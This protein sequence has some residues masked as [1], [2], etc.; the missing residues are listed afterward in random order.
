MALGLRIDSW[1]GHKPAPKL[2]LE[3]SPSEPSVR[4]HTWAALLSTPA[5]RVLCARCQ[6]KLTLDSNTK[7]SA[8]GYW[9]ETTTS[10]IP[11]VC[12]WVFVFELLGLRT[13][14]WFFPFLAFS[15]KNNKKLLPW[16][17]VQINGGLGEKKRTNKQ[18]SVLY[19]GFSFHLEADGFGVFYSHLLKSVCYFATAL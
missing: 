12:Q 13:N 11:V 2:A 5:S 4:C 1:F 7:Q 19:L 3:M 6:L 16:I 8:R 15:P 18:G 9:G 17:P 14:G 10:H